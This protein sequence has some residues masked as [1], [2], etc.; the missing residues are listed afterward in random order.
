MIWCPLLKIYNW[1]CLCP[2]P[3]LYNTPLK[4]L[5]FSYIVNLAPTIAQLFSFQWNLHHLLVSW[6]LGPVICIPALFDC[7]SPLCHLSAI[8]SWK[9][10]D[11]L[12][13][14][15][16]YFLQSSIYLSWLLF[17]CGFFAGSPKADS[18]D[19]GNGTDCNLRT[20]EGNAKLEVVVGRDEQAEMPCG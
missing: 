12:D 14:H 17:Q 5:P 8:L 4:C 16:S 3:V 9:T 18:H 20:F 10:S 2:L 15:N 6:T 19:L 13:I 1:T 11:F 7:Q